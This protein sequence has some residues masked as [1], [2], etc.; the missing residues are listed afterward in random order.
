[1]VAA[2]SSDAE[3]SEGSVDWRCQDNVITY[4][5]IHRVSTTDARQLTLKASEVVTVRWVDHS[6]MYADAMPKKRMIQSSTDTD[7]SKAHMHHSRSSNPGETQ[8]ERLVTMQFGREWI[9]CRKL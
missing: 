1:M 3:M 4:A 8:V 7:A 2:R 9:L 6:G 5:L